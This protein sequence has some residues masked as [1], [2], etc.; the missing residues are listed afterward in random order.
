VGTMDNWGHLIVYLKIHFEI[1][2]FSD[3]GK[4]LLVQPNDVLHCFWYLSRSV[5]RSV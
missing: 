2:E 1:I 4:Q 3:T 5:G